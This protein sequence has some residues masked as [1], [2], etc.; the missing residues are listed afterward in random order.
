MPYELSTWE[1]LARV[2]LAAAL[3]LAIGWDREKK[4]KAAGLRTMALVSLGAAGVMIA[5]IEMSAD[6]HA[7]DV[8]L[9]P[10][11]VISGV[12]GGIGFIGGG[13]ILH[14]RHHVRG[15]T[16][17]ATIWAAAGI[18]VASGAGLYRLA[19]I[20]TGVVLVILVVVTALKGTLLPE[21][22]GAPRNDQQ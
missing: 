3:G 19:I 18:G 21:R 17:A 7:D 2:A 15:L 11:R 1:L 9:D 10:L 4:E 5:A 14:S 20:L 13:A 8:R 12:I 6:L 22:E 16:T